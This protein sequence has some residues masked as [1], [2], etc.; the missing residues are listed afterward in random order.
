MS[1]KQGS[2]GDNL[3][4]IIDLSRELSITQ[5]STV[6]LSDEVEQ[7]VLLNNPGYELKKFTRIG[8][9]PVIYFGDYKNIKFKD[10]GI[11]YQRVN[12]GLSEKGKSDLADR[13]LYE[14]EK[15][16]KSIVCIGKV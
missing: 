14:G 2:N 12:V 13:L 15:E 3:V 9:A 6:P 16:M 1:E 7:R 8:K 5:L 10:A 4:N 11:N